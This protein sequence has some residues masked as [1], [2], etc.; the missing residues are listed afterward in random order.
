M[1][2]GQRTAAAADSDDRWNIHSSFI[3]N[4]HQRN[5]RLNVGDLG[6]VYDTKKSMYTIKSIQMFAFEN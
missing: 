5:Y 1:L 2:G 4:T 6:T 3:F